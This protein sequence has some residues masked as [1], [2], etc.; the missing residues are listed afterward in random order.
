VPPASLELEITEST[1]MENAERTVRILDEL[2]NMGLSLAIDDFGT[3]YSSLSALQ[4]FPITTLK[5]DQSFVRDAATD[6]DDAIIVNTIIQMGH[7]LNLD[8]IAEGVEFPSQLRFLRS[9][10]CDFVQG[11]LFGYPMSAPEFMALLASQQQ[12]TAAFKAMFA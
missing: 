7:G 6:A 2:Y 8:V 9:A 5:I 12:G 1:L 11:L 4:K 10:G 3:G